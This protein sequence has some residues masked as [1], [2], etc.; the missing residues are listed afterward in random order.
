[1]FVPA[2][3][4]LKVPIRIEVFHAIPRAGAITITERKC[5]NWMKNTVPF[6]W[7]HKQNRFINYRMLKTAQSI[8]C[9]SFKLRA[10]LQN[11]GT[12]IFDVQKTANPFEV[13]S[14]KLMK[15]VLC[16]KKYVLKCLRAS[17]LACSKAK[18]MLETC[19][20]L[21]G[22]ASFCTMICTENTQ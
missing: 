3:A 14:A 11:W 2:R 9:F 20:C 8:R 13:L 17:W 12:W 21:C 16:V 6:W 7:M 15:T 1:M 19:N 18:C 4:P 5:Q 10:N 22:S